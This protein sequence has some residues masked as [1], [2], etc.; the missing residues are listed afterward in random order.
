MDSGW[1]DRL[2]NIF[3]GLLCTL[4]LLIT[5]YPIYF[6]VVASVSDP[7]AV[8]KGSVYLWPKSFTLEAYANVFKES[9][10]WTGY[11]NT[12][13]YTLFGTLWNLVLTIPAAYVLSK[14]DLPG[15]AILSWFFFITMYF[16]GGI[17][18]S[19]MLYKDL[20]LLNTRWACILGAG[21][22]CWNLIVTRTFFTGTI[23]NE[24]YEAAEIDGASEMKTFFSI[25]IPLSAAIIAIMA[26]FYGVEHWNEYF[27][28]MC[29]LTSR[30]YY[31]LQLVLRDIL[32]EN[33]QAVRSME[34][35][36]A[37]GAAEAAARKAYM[38]EVMKYALIFISA[39]P[40][41]AAYPFVQKYFVKGVMIGS[42]KG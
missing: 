26:L 35:V 9:Q 34:N 15:R 23:P 13:I 36:T 7:V 39:A 33:Q 17:V 3:N 25:A 19:Y 22:N 31:P 41:L 28:A 40:M 18:P 2:F 4:I 1:R 5:I 21:V 30:K 14:R 6:V 37:D 24:V 10:I 8:V 12:I 38:A 20:G 42:V 27:W 11:G 16:S 32:I 29:S